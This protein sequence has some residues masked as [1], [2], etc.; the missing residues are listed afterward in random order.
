MMQMVGHAGR[1][2]KESHIFFTT[3]EIQGAYFWDEKN[4]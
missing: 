3:P 1:N 2:G 4:P